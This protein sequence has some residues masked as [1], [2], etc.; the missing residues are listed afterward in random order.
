MYIV[1]LLTQ[2]GCPLLCRDKKSRRQEKG[3][4]KDKEPLSPTSGA[5]EAASS[6]DFLP[7]AQ[8]SGWLTLPLAHIMLGGDPPSLLTILLCATHM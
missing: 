3:K 8:V 2:C 6:D 4:K 7:P 1:F 5:A